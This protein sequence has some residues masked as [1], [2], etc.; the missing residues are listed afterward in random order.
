MEVNL[1]KTR[2]SRTE[3][4]GRE[5]RWKKWNVK[6]V[7]VE[8]HIQLCLT[9]MR[10]NVKGLT[11]EKLTKA[12]IDLIIEYYKKMSQKFPEFISNDLMIKYW[13]ERRDKGRS[14]LIG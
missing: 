8:D 3:L 7:S 14:K 9:Q 5:Q 12:E 11:M 1:L 4:I 2:Q 13:E 6:F 10:M